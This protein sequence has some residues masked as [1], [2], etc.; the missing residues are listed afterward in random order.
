MIALRAEH[1]ADSHSAHPQNPVMA[2]Y[3]EISMTWNFNKKLPTL[4]MH[5]KAMPAPEPN[6]P[7]D[8]TSAPP[9]EST[10]PSGQFDENE[11]SYWPLSLQNDVVVGHW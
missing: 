4:C 6:L 3:L 5:R 9:E 10:H 2:V 1:R 11:K 8:L 7:E